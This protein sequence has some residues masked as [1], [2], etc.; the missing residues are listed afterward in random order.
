MK[1]TPMR[2]PATRTT[3]WIEVQNLIR[4]ISLAQLPSPTIRQSKCLGDRL[5]EITRGE[6]HTTLSAPVPRR[7]WLLGRDLDLLGLWLLLDRLGDGDLQ[8]AVGEGC[9]DLFDL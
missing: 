5:R 7:F 4:T 2:I 6:G 3:A 8:N 1:D 9:F